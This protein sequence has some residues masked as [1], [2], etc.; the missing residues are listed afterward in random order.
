[1]AESCSNASLSS[2]SSLNSSV[3]DTEDDQIIASI[4]AQDENS[5]ADR[6]L[7]KRLS[8]LDSIPVISFFMSMIGFFSLECACV[9]IICI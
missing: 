7:G 3:Q 9:K 5:H 6:S 8:H 4:L 1:M 2:S